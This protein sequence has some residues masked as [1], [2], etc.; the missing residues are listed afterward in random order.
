M[1]NSPSNIFLKLLSWTKVASA[2]E[3]LS[4]LCV[5]IPLDIVTGFYDI[6]ENNLI[7]LNRNNT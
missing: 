7:L 3:G 6:F 2:L 5:R 1:T 4:Y